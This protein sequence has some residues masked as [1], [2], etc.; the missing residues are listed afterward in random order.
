M[1]M[2]LQKDNKEGDVQD[3]TESP[4]D[5]VNNESGLIEIAENTESSIHSVNKESGGLREM[6]E[7]RPYSLDHD[8]S[9]NK[10]LDAENRVPIEI[11]Q[12]GGGLRIKCDAGTFENLKKELLK[13]YTN[14]E[15]YDQL[16]ATIIR[17]H[18]NDANEPEVKVKVAYPSTKTC[19]TINIYNT[20]SSYLINGRGLTRFQSGEL[21]AILTNLNHIIMETSAL[22][23]QLSKC[24]VKLVL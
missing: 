6:T 16:Q 15:N 18:D 7:N 22:H 13:F 2:G 20:T 14:Y 21:P 24:T 19:F 9:L 5:S 12:T 23:S 8:A 17:C 4:N 3:T 1:E 11:Y 10:K